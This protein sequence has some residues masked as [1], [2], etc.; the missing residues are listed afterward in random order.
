MNQ[1]FMSFVVGG[2]TGVLTGLGALAVYYAATHQSR[3]TATNVA[4]DWLRDLRVW[5][6]EAVDVLAEASYTCQPV[7][8]A[9]VLQEQNGILCCR[10]SLRGLIDRG[11]FFYPMNTRKNM[12]ITSRKLTR[13][14]AT[15]RWMLW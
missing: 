7:D 3:L 4:A 13:A 8:P 9:S 2:L 10:Y 5:A 12:V 6:S 11:R 14:T 1:E 15:Q